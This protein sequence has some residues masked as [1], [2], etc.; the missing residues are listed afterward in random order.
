M[1]H[2][3]GIMGHFAITKKELFPQSTQADATKKTADLPKKPF[4]NKKNTVL[5]CLTPWFMSANYAVYES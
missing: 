4:P 3:I 1:P 2:Y 5:R